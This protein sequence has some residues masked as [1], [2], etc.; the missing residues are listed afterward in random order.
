VNE[1]G[2]HLYLLECDGRSIYTGITTDVERR[3]AEHAA[4]LSRAARYTRGARQVRLLYAVEL[5][6][7]GLTARA[8]YRLKQLPRAKKLRVAEQRPDRG[9]LLDLLGLAP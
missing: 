4:G 1:S 9:E 7:R 3:L 6:D 8:E 5:G 2:W